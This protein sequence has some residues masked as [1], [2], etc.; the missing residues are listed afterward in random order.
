MR[1]LEH[2]QHTH[3]KILSVKFMEPITIYRTS[4]LN[5]K[6]LVFVGI[7]D[8]ILIASVTILPVKNYSIYIG[9]VNPL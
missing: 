3:F 9:C 5:M 7:G 4:K 1:S 2:L 6:K 8:K